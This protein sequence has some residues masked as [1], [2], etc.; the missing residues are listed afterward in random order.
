MTFASLGVV[1]MGVW[2]VWTGV[3]FLNVYLEEQIGRKESLNT[4]E[5]DN[6][7]RICIQLYNW[8]GGAVWALAV[9]VSLH[10]AAKYYVWTKVLN[11]WC[12]GVFYITLVTIGFLEPNK[13]WRLLE[14]AQD[15]QGGEMSTGCYTA[16]DNTQMQILSNVTYYYLQDTNWY[17]AWE[18]RTQAKAEYGWT[19]LVAPIV[20]NGSAHECQFDPPIYAA[21]VTK[22]LTAEACFFNTPLSPYRT[23]RK[24][25]QAEWVEMWL[26][27]R[28]PYPS[29]PSRND[30]IFEW[31]SP[32]LSDTQEF[33]AK[34]DKQRLDQWRNICISWFALTLPLLLSSLVAAFRIYATETEIDLDTQ[35]D[36]RGTNY[37]NDVNQSFTESDTP[38]IPTPPPPLD[39]PS[40]P[41][42]QYSPA[43]HPL[44]PTQSE[45]QWCPP[46]VHKSLPAPLPTQ[47]EMEWCPPS[48]HDSLPA[49]R[50]RTPPEMQV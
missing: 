11:A 46:S 3:M 47:P 36:E 6:N 23:I 22:T 14:K 5:V 37:A 8:L 50:L 19:W 34:V 45:M 20:Y 48:V 30:Y 18:N 2:G 17:V 44:M 16:I 31:D 1:A 35:T 38:R 21:C 41:P 12:C 42:L 15:S 43:P 39:W 25:R 27:K 26:F 10:F 24:L 29:G 32:T 4:Y 33:I 49:P 13:S 9:F 40:H 7:N 28:F